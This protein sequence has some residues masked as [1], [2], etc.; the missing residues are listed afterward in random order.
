MQLAGPKWR[1]KIRLS[2]RNTP[3]VFKIGP[4][5]LLFTRD[6]IF[7]V[8]LLDFISMLMGLLRDSDPFNS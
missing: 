1:G 7:L 6:R 4:K 5:T 8:Q 2:S 3:E